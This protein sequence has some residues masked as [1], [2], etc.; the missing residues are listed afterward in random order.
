MLVEITFLKF[1]I[2]VLGDPI[3]AV[4]ASIGGFLLLSGIGSAVS[5]KWE[6]SKS[7]RWAFPGIAIIASAGFFTLFHGAD[8]LLA[9]G[10]V[11]RVLAFLVSLAPAAFLMGMPFPVGLSRM[12]AVDSPAIPYAWG[13][14]GFF[15]VAG[16][17]LASIGALWFGFHATIAAGAILYL[18][19]GAVF[20]SLVRG[21]TPLPY[22]GDES[23]MSPAGC[24]EGHRTTPPGS[25]T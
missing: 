24:V 11:L 14:N 22:S 23:G 8:F 9:K 17:S 19:A 10:E 21:D 4:T 12:A 1:G 15:S 25:R 3:R 5:G 13:V 2:L 20:P 7:M 18:L 6:A 16:A